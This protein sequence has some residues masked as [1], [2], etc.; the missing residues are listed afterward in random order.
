MLPRMIARPGGRWRWTAAAAAAGVIAVAAVGIDAAV[1]GGSPPAPWCQAKPD[2]AWRS[3]T[4]RHTVPLPQT[5]DA[6][7]L[8]LGPDARTFFAVVHTKQGFWGVAQ[9]DALNGKVTPIKAFSKGHRGAAAGGEFDGRR[10]VWTVSF[11][12]DLS[13][14]SIWA[15]DSQT[16]HLQRLAIAPQDV[17]LGGP[18]VRNGIA[19]WTRPVRASPGGPPFAFKPPSVVHI[20]DLRTGRDT[21]IR[22]RYASG[23]LLF[24]GRLIAWSV[25]LGPKGLRTKLHVASVTSG[26]RVATPRALRGVGTD[27][28]GLDTDGH[29]VA[30]TTGRQGIGESLWWSPSLQQPAQRIARAPGRHTLDPPFQIGGRYL[31]IGMEPGLYVA[32]TRVHRYVLV[33]SGWGSVFTGPHALLVSQPAPPRV[34]HYTRMRISVIPVRDVPAIPPCAG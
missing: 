16:G 30:Y 27:F 12:T 3:L 8:A 31:G 22:S 19:A 20:Y 9:V 6:Y 28:A 32:D 7:P 15:W 34:Q 17:A 26:K 25:G 33:H 23:P 18:V 21:V 4:A 24:A 29:E 1:A 11:G 13:G 10:L 5:T 2:A 14:W